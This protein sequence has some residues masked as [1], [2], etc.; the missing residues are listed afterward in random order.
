MPTGEVVAVAFGALALY[1]FV[2]GALA[3]LVIRRTRARRP[4]VVSD[5]RGV[6]GPGW[7][8]DLAVPAEWLRGHAAAERT[9][10]M[11]AGDGP[12]EPPQPPGA[13]G[14]PQA[15]ERPSRGWARWRD[16][17]AALP[18]AVF[19]RKDRDVAAL[20]SARPLVA[21]AFVATTC[22]VAALIFSNS[23]VAPGRKL[24]SGRTP[25]VPGPHAATIPP[26]TSRQ[27]PSTTSPAAGDGATK[28]SPPAPGRSAAQ[29]ASQPYT[30][31]NVLE[32]PLLGTAGGGEPVAASG[33]SIDSSLAGE[34]MP[35]GPSGVELV[36]AVSG[37]PATPTPASPAAPKAAAKAA[38]TTKPGTEQ[39]KPAAKVAER[40]KASKSKSELER[41]AKPHRKT[42][43]RTRPAAKA[44]AVATSKTDARSRWKATAGKVHGK[45]KMP[46]ASTLKATRALRP[47]PRWSERQPAASHSGSVRHKGG[48]GHRSGGPGHRR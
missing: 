45:A 47:V 13:G 1:T 25:A 37:Q 14:E 26:A 27:P 20:P 2:A 16:A 43:A 17:V 40:A 10:T 12:A 35:S 41:E 9:L 23:G 33:P 31:L 18:A 36:A 39:A 38:A 19:D 4:V 44:M 30:P 11:V 15:L 42:V 21:A 22:V 29:P 28:P 32:R 7:P 3:S 46:A 8:A 5:E 24:W 34:A 48:N 6:L